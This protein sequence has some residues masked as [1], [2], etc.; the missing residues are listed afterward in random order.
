M[1]GYLHYSAQSY[2]PN[3]PL[4]YLQQTAYIQN[5]TGG[6]ISG[7]ITGGIVTAREDPLSQNLMRNNY[8][9]PP[10]GSVFQNP[11]GGP[12]TVYMHDPSVFQSKN[13]STIQGTTAGGQKFTEYY[14]NG[15][16]VKTTF[17]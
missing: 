3:H 12:P 4:L 7:Q 15:V 8:L 17:H 11:Y 10:V 6:W 9:G 5:S 1:S 13:E 16:I 14:K 2:S